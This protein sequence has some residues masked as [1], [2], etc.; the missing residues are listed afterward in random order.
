MGG[1]K[2]KRLFRKLIEKTLDRTLWRTGFRWVYEPFVKQ[3]VLR[4]VEAFVSAELQPI[5]CSSS[6]VAINWD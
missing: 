4:M 3:A 1:L 6:H 2:E 5:F